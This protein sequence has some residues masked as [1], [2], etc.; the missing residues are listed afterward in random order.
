MLNLNKNLLN[1]IWHLTAATPSQTNPNLTKKDLVFEVI[2]RNL[3][4]IG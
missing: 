4:K 1:F 3:I 2:E